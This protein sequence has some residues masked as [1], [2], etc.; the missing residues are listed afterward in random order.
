MR[1]EELVECLV[2]TFVHVLV[3]DGLSNWH[4]LNVPQGPPWMISS[5]TLN[6]EYFKIIRIKL[7]CEQEDKRC[8][9]CFSVCPF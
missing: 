7:L 5:H 6:E 2:T 3:F 9:F 4:R 1:G 8:F